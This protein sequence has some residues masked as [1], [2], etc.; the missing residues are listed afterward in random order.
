MSS[1][2]L[3]TAVRHHAS[4]VVA[5]RVDPYAARADLT[6]FD[7]LQ[8]RLETGRWMRGH[9]GTSVATA[10][11]FRRGPWF[12]EGFERPDPTPVQLALKAAATAP[13]T[14]LE[15]LVSELMVGLLEQIMGVDTAWR[16]GML[17]RLSLRDLA[18]LL[19]LTPVKV[20]TD[21]A[22]HADV[23]TAASTGLLPLRV[24]HLDALSSGNLLPTTRPPDPA[25]PTDGSLPPDPAIV[26][27]AALV[28]LVLT[29]FNRSVVSATAGP[30]QDSYVRPAGLDWPLDA[31]GHDGPPPAVPLH[32]AVAD[33]AAVLHGAVRT[34]R[35]YPV[36]VIRRCLHRIVRCLHGWMSCG[37][38]LLCT[39]Q[40]ARRDVEAHLCATDDPPITTILSDAAQRGPSA[41]LL[42]LLHRACRVGVGLLEAFQSE[43]R[44]WTLPPTDGDALTLA[45]RLVGG[46]GSP[47]VPYLL[48]QALRDLL[49]DQAPAVYLSHR[50]TLALAAD[51]IFTLFMR[52]RG[53]PP[54]RNLPGNAR[55]VEDLLD[56]C[57]SRAHVL[58]YLYHWSHPSVVHPTAPLLLGPHN[59][60]TE[61]CCHDCRDSDSDDDTAPVGAVSW[62]QV[63]AALGGVVERHLLVAAVG[64]ETVYTLAHHPVN[65]QRLGPGVAELLRRW[66]AA[67]QHNPAAR[68]QA[69]ESVLQAL[70]DVLDPWQGA[71]FLVERAPW[72]GWER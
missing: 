17:G 22:A 41:I 50:A 18:D 27:N 52:L 29:Q 49:H 19:A 8:V 21:F 31:L 28:L 36:E 4:A 65:Q 1:S 72:C 53:D 69:H 37:Q 58:R 23:R 43:S 7:D 59:T 68:H 13:G 25:N 70:L 39:D 2:Q 44:Q 9:W 67:Q 3:A 32:V 26:A 56:R 54:S 45:R 24:A 12:Q 42:L 71:L 63:A 61:T 62:A 48:P 30:D 57:P 38:G 16:T 14:Q 47:S 64:P 66:L 35:P 51:H 55:V 33:A 15:V 11:Q 6:S 40:V 34:L 60:T 20:R 10:Q 5:G 46:E